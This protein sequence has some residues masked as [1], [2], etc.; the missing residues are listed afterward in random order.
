MLVPGKRV[1]ALG[2][3]GADAEL[4]EGSAVDTR[5]FPPG[6]LAPWFQLLS[7]VWDSRIPLLNNKVLGFVL[8]VSR[9]LKT[10]VLA[11]V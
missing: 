4:W 2:L 9:E 8:T 5:A 3:V 6:F 10:A 11:A 1:A 7:H